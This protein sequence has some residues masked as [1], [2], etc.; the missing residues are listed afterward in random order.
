MEGFFSEVGPFSI[1]ELTNPTTSAGQPTLFRN[2]FSWTQRAS[3]LAWES[4][5]GV[6]FSPCGDRVKDPGAVCPHWNDT[7]AA[8][9][10]ALFLCNFF[11]AYPERVSNQFF[12]TGESYAGA[13]IADGQLAD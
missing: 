2:P 5:A 7:L 3:V 12:I 13:T 8:S 4:P 10:N 9:D 11:R 1:N 6:G